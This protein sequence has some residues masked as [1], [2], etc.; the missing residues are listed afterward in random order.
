[1]WR[2][3]FR[4]RR[5]ERVVFM[6]EIGAGILPADVQ[7][8]VVEPARQII[9]VGD[10]GASGRDGIPLCEGAQRSPHEPQRPMRGGSAADAGDVAHQQIHE[11]DNVAV[12][13]GQPAVHVKFAQLEIGIQAQGQ[14]GRTILDGDGDARLAFAIS[15]CFGVKIA[16]C[17]AA[18]T[19]IS[20]EQKIEHAATPTDLRYSRFR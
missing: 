5:L 10:M 14:Q 19:D 15:P 3:F 16:D 4:L 8:K 18:L 9:V 13:D 12:L 6:G 7:E 11:T 1:M 20:A 17:Q 2:F